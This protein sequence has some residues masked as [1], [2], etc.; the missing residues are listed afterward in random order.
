M[1][2]GRRGMLFRSRRLGVEVREEARAGLRRDDVVHLALRGDAGGGEELRPVHDEVE[3]HLG[4]LVGR[5]VVAR[6]ADALR[7]VDVVVE[8]R[9]EAVCS[10]SLHKKRVT[11]IHNDASLKLSF[12]V[13]RE[14]Q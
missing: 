9:P 13:Y 6:G 14:C 1:L 11:G 5:G 4:D 8:Q 2:G 7:D 10:N 12:Y 3:L